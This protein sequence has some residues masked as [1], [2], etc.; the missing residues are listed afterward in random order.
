MCGIVGIWGRSEESLVD[1]ML[2]RIA[3]RGPDS[4]GICR[5]PEGYSALG[6]CRLSIIDPDGGDQPLLSDRPRCGVVVNGE[7]YNHLEIRRA[8]GE[9]RFRSG[10]DSES[11]LQ[12]Y[13][14][15]RHDA[16]RRILGTGP[17]AYAGGN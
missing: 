3:H 9:T 16:V 8:V 5:D 7:I 2:S 15:G 12:A 10:S 11:I 14:D 6:S 1:E 13:L 4:V 17:V